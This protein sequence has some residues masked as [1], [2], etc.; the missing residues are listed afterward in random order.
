MINNDIIELILKDD[1]SQFDLDDYMVLANHKELFGLKVEL[2][3]MIKEALKNNN[4]EDL[5]K[6]KEYVKNNINT[7]AEIVERSN[8]VSID[9]G[10]LHVHFKEDFERG[11][12]SL[13]NIKLLV[14][15]DII[16]YYAY[17]T[18]YQLNFFGG[19]IKRV[20]A[21]HEVNLVAS[22]MIAS[23]YA[24]E[25]FIRRESRRYKYLNTSN[26]KRDSFIRVLKNR[27]KHYLMFLVKII[28]YLN[29][30]DDNYLLTCDFKE[31]TKYINKESINFRKHV[32]NKDNKNNDDK[33]SKVE[34]SWSVVVDK[35]Y[36]DEE[37]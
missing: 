19:S 29:T 1:Y 24:F 37:E 4:G 6:I 18:S 36:N 23:P 31:L 3:D 16:S 9:D 2:K 11:L 22:G 21:F 5:V 13:S 10:N 32:V 12:E 27:T 17:N 14:L 8:N 30:L 34:E 7:F 20:Q 35:Y 28:N 25:L 26:L 15:M 33:V